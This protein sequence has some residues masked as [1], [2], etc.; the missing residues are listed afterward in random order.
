VGAVSLGGPAGAVV[1][2]RLRPF[3][4]GR[5]PVPDLE[6]LISGEPPIAGRVRGRVSGSVRAVGVD[7]REMIECAS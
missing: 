4:R 3:V 2:G 5:R 1:L 7:T 6:A